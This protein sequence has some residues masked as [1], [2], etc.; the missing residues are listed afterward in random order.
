[1]PA[2]LKIFVSSGLPLK[3]VPLVWCTAW[4]VTGC[5][6]LAMA[7]SAPLKSLRTSALVA[8]QHIAGHDVVVED[9]VAAAMTGD[10]R[11]AAVEWVVDALALAHDRVVDATVGEGVAASDQH[12]RRGL[13]PDPRRAAAPAS[14]P[15][16]SRRR[17]GR[18]RCRPATDRRARGGASRGPHVRGGRAGPGHPG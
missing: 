14:R 1:M 8:G 11:G 6:W 3:R 16:A 2:R 5:S 12:P 17:R 10:A 13:V 9:R 4:S 15:G 18:G 7:S